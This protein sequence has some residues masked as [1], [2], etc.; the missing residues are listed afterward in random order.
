VTELLPVQASF[1]IGDE[2]TVEA[3][4]LDVPLTVSLWRLADEVARVEVTP[5]RP[6]ASFGPLE[7]GGYGV[8]AADGAT[9]ALDVLRRPLERLRYGFVSE[10]TP[11]RDS[12]AVADNV[13]RLHLNAVQ[14][15]DWMYRHAELLPPQDEFGDALGRVVSLAT[16]ERL[17]GAVRGAGSL[18]LGYAAVYATGTG[19]LPRWA[20]EQ[21]LHPDGSPWMLADFLWIVDPSSRPWLEHLTAN[22]CASAQRVGF[23]GFHLDQ[24][25]APKHARRRDGRVVDL[26]SA[27]VTLIEHLRSELPDAALIFNNV[28]DF[29]TEATAAAPQDA[30]YIEPWSPH[31]ELHDLAWLVRKAAA[32]APGRP[33]VLAAYLSAYDGTEAAHDALR[34]ELASVLSNGATCLLFGEEDAILVDPYY[35]RHRRL[36]DPGLAIAKAYLDFTVRYGDLLFEPTAADVTRTHAGGINEEVA[37]VGG[38]G[39]WARVIE[40]ERRRVVSLVDLAGQ[41]DRRWDALKQPIALRTGVGVAFERVHDGR[42]FFASPESSPHSVQLRPRRE[43]W[44]DVVDVPPF[45]C[46][47]LVWADADMES[48]ARRD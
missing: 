1:A 42:Y 2:V 30:T 35:V 33:V 18:P 44:H 43:R 27:F 34:L 36:D 15:Y 11:G 48:S 17:A 25:G 23:A 37:V 20:D 10:F 29:P 22:L 45:T 40:T 4:G 31:D 5:Q 6:T 8:E 12:N 13:R 3:R 28:N 46:W 32:A 41:E 38:E 24:Y 14:F 16:V 21:L 7:P 39:I 26:A 47:A 9:T 19:E